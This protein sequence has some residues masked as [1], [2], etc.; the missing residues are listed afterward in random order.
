MTVARS[1]DLDRFQKEAIAAVDAGRSVLVAAPTSSGKTVVAEHAIHK[2]LS[3]GR[4]AFYT[5]PIK[6]LSNQKFRD[7]GELF[8]P[9]HVGL[10]TGDQV[11]APEA[12]IVV[13]TTEVLRNMLYAKSE[14]VND[15]SWVVLDEVH[16]LEDPYRG[17]VWEEVLLHLAPSVG[18]VALSATVSNAAELGEWIAAVRGPTEVIVETRRPVRLRSHYLVA[19][20]GRRGVE[21]RVHRAALLTKDGKP[22][23]Q[24]RRFDQ[25]GRGSRGRASGGAKRRAWVPPRRSE[26]V[27]DLAGDGLLPAI[28]FIFSRAGCDEARDSVVRDGLV[29]NDENESVAVDNWITERLLTIGEADRDALGVDGW[30][31]ALRRG[32]ASHHAGLV[33]VFKEVTEELFIAGLV[34][35]VYATETLALG[36]NLPARSVI[37]DRLTKFTGQTHEVLTAGQFTQLTGRAGRRGLDTEGHAFVCWSP[38]VPFDRVAGLA[39]SREFVLRSA[40][41]PTYNMVANMVENRS[42]AEAMDLLARSFAQFQADR[43]TA[44]RLRRKAEKHEE[45]VALR[46]RLEGLSNKPNVPV[47]VREVSV[48][49]L[50]PGDVVVPEAGVVQVVLS[51]ANR[52][53]GRIRVRTLDRE[54][55][56]GILGEDG[57]VALPNLIGQVDLPSPFVPSDPDFRRMAQTLL[58]GFAPVSLMDEQQSRKPEVHDK[59]SAESADTANSR[60]RLARI[61]RDLSREASRPVNMERDLT[62]RFDAALSVLESRKMSKAWALTDRGRVLIGIHNEA[63]LLVAEV[64]HAGLLRGL[65]APMVAS[66]ISC[67]TYRKRGPGEPS[68]VQLGGEF[69]ACFQ[70]IANLAETIAV[71]ERVAGLN[72]KDPPDPGFAHYMHAWASGAELAE[73]LDEELLAGEFV[74]NVRL[75]AD[76]LRQVGLIGETEIAAT[77]LEAESR[78]D[79]GVVSLSAGRIDATDNPKTVS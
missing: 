48:A 59:P 39:G 17:A 30:A 38:F 54:G 13:M 2:T 61:E 62:A 41:M 20:R 5:A 37:I 43:Q 1:F 77:A 71:D 3:A 9:E 79:R 24:G 52:G 67:L 21:R 12:P 68:R 45:A 33:P 7:L 55:T 75:V 22:N 4:R 23:L 42:R 26:V 6:A 74:R 35:L 65:G 10:M 47:E 27:A 44:T 25:D 76:L 70:K 31:V 58:D 36:V 78:I 18:V 46:R 29:L 40:F 63:D 66:V 11:V 72:P 28:H 19:E 32:I 60:R 14:A 51:V 73:V 15:L 8:G 57:G 50:R 53:G 69:P 34:K 64:L 49:V 56:I 16:Y